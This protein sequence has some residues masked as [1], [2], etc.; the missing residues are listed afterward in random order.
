MTR[1][2]TTGYCFGGE[3]YFLDSDCSYATHNLRGL[4]A[5]EV[6]GLAF[7]NISHVSVITHPGFIEIADLEKYFSTSKAPLL[8]NSC[9]D[10]RPFPAEKQAKA[11]EIFGSNKFAPGYQ[12]TYAEGCTHGFAVRGDVVCHRYYR[13][14]NCTYSVLTSNPCERAIQR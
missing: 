7:E 10:D 2:G 4:V 12:R 1:F 8:I 6:F 3:P 9:E 11:D 14:N 13:R 5:R